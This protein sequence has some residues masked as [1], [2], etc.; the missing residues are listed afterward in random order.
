[1]TLVPSAIGR[2]N[3]RI[4]SSSNAEHLLDGFGVQF[5]NA[6]WK[7]EAKTSAQGVAM[8]LFS[9][10]DDKQQWLCALSI[11]PLTGKP[12][13]YLATIDPTQLHGSK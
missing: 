9:K 1:V 12:G 2:T 10:T 8:E 7:A 11:Y 4:T 5:V 6:G 13:E 3:A